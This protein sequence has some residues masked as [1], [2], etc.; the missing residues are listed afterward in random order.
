[1][2]FLQPVLRV[3]LH[4]PS[5]PPEVLMRIFKAASPCQ[6]EHDPSVMRPWST[7]LDDLRFRKG[8]VLVCKAFAGPATAALYEDVVFRRM[9]QIPALARTLSS[10]VGR[11]V[12]PLIQRIRMDSCVIW[13]PCAEVVKNDLLFILR[14]CTALRAFLF[15]AHPNFPTTNSAHED[16]PHAWDGFNPAWLLHDHTDD[17]GRLFQ[18]ILSS[19]LRELEISMPLS[20]TQVAELHELLSAARLLR[21]LKLGQIVAQPFVRDAS[22]LSTRTLP[23]LE[24][25]QMYVDHPGFT[26][27]VSSQWEL[28]ALT[29]LTMIYCEALPETL[30]KQHGRGLTYLHIFPKKKDRVYDYSWVACSVN[31]LDALSEWCPVLEHLVFPATR[32]NNHATSILSRIRSPTLRYLDIWCHNCL[33]TRE[34]VEAEA[35][36]AV[37]QGHLPSL[38]QLRRLRKVPRIDLP[39]ICHPSFVTGD[40]ARLYRLP[41][42]FVVQTS[43]CVVPDS[44]LQGDLPWFVHLPPEDDDTGT[45]VYESESGDEDED[46]DEDGDKDE[47]EDNEDDGD[48]ED[49]DDEDEDTSEAS[50][51]AYDPSDNEIESEGSSDTEDSEAHISDWE[52]DIPALKEARLKEVF[53]RDTILS[54]FTA[55]QERNVDESSDA[56]SE[57]EGVGGEDAEPRMSVS[58]TPTGVGPP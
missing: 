19:S 37:E 17:V 52:L 27:Y 53:D 16:S 38:V 33:A 14:R 2:Q 34:L 58:P 45:F 4:L 21:T 7:W 36:D 8:L 29:S 32:P 42:L 44:G 26:A 39:L 46:E 9:G 30:L 6:Y 12:S 51:E 25:L 24:A 3:P 35:D 31:H 13:A 48:D 11:N 50:D 55:S 10:G 43:W 47:D 28:P 22:S 15:H 57:G 23:Q 41:G 49:E 54:M 1:M 20:E 56:S 18:R 5:L 40:D